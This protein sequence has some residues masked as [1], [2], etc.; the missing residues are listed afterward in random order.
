MEPGETPPECAVREIL[1]ETGLKA[2]LVC[3]PATWLASRDLS[4]APFPWE[5]QGIP[6]LLVL[7][8]DSSPE[9][10]VNLMYLARATGHPRPCAEIRGL[11][12]LRPED[13]LRICREQLPY[14]DYL[15]TGG[16]AVVRAP[17]P[18]S[19]ALDPGPQVKL[20]ARLLPAPGALPLLH[21][22]PGPGE[23]AE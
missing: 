8:R 11:L 20:L 19:M 22:V 4:L 21:S 17:Y 6:P 15:T 1:E 14:A 23:S 12:L 18:P 3:P 9:G 7:P 10:P 5:G 16:A 2:E 13:V